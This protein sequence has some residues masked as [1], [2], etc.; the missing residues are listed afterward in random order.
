MADPRTCHRHSSYQ[1]SRF[2]ASCNGWHFTSDGSHA[3]LQCL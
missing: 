2:R 1:T 3:L